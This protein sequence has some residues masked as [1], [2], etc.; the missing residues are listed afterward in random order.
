[1]GP[2]PL[3]AT[4]RE[5]ITPLEFGSLPKLQDPVAVVG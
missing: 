1:M 3:A 4:R 5:G 2:H